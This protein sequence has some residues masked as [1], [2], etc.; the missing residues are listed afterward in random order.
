LGHVEDADAR[1]VLQKNLEGL[2]KLLKA[3]GEAEA[4]RTYR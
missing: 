3:M 2:K 1:V 4:L